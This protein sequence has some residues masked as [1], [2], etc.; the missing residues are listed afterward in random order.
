MHYERRHFINPARGS[1]SWD[2]STNYLLVHQARMGAQAT[3]I[4][5]WIIAGDGIPVP[6]IQPGSVIQIS[7]IDRTALF[8]AAIST[9]L[10]HAKDN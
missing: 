9:S 4:G 3:E 1:F 2:R 10:L 6:D 8:F 7:V 5:I